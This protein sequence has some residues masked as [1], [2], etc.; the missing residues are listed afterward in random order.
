MPSRPRPA[1]AATR[2][3]PSGSGIKEAGGKFGW[4]SRVP[5]VSYTTMRIIDL[6]VYAVKE[7][8][9]PRIEAALKMGLVGAGAGGLLQGIRKLLHRGDPE[10]SPSILNGMLLGGGLGAAGGAGL[11]H[12]AGQQKSPPLEQWAG[13]TPLAGPG[14]PLHPVVRSPDQT[15]VPAWAQ[16]Q[17]NNEFLMR[18]T[19]RRLMQGAVG[20]PAGAMSSGLGDF[21][22][23]YMP[24]ANTAQVNKL[25]QDAGDGG[26]AR[27]GQSMM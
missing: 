12:W 4:H 9:D 16:D 6:S 19:T 22:A 20:G 10:D 7:A 25:I 26:A 3:S 27:A 11:A 14:N 18:D 17:V 13:N 23:P 1:S 24:G 15:P 2:T 5:V 21:G 8:A